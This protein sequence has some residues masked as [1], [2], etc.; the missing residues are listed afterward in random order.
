MFV[1]E[2]PKPIDERCLAVFRFSMDEQRSKTIVFVRRGETHDNVARMCKRYS[3]AAPARLSRSEALTRNGLLQSLATGKRLAGHT[4]NKLYCSMLIRARYTAKAIAS[5]RHSESWEHRV[6][7]NEIRTSLVKSME[8]WPKYAQVCIEQEAF[9]KRI[10]EE[11]STQ[12]GHTLV[13]THG[14][15]IRYLVGESLGIPHMNRH[16]LLPQNCSIW[17]LEQAKEEWRLLLA[18]DISHL[19]DAQL[20]YGERRLTPF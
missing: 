8:P 5:Y 10:W 11:L 19:T 12:E 17:I 2:L 13:V 3:L 20:C 18:N 16:L 7:L 9:M 14:N 15:V 1:R 4:F 6:E